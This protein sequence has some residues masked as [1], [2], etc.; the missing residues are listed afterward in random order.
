MSAAR[1]WKSKSRLRSPSRTGSANARIAIA[2]STSS[3]VK[4]SASAEE[5]LLTCSRGMTSPYSG[6]RNALLWSAHDRCRPEAGGDWLEQGPDPFEHDQRFRRIDT[7]IRD[8][9][10]GGHRFHKNPHHIV[11]AIGQMHRGLVDAA[12]RVEKDIHTAGLLSRC[13]H[14]DV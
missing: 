11:V 6:S 3:S 13:T 10:Q 12:V 4:P 2:I 14:L 1:A 9:D 7:V 5:C 8:A